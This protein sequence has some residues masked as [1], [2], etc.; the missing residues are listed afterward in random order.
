MS[1]EVRVV[2]SGGVEAVHRG[3]IAIVDADGRTIRAAGDVDATYFARSSLKPFQVQVV[4]RL[5][6]AL[7]G[8]TLALGCAS[9]AGT[10]GHLEVVRRMLEE[11]GLDESS[12]ATPR[13]WPGSL[14]GRDAAVR[15]G[16]R[17][18]QRIFHNCSGKHAGMLRA[19]VASDLP[20]ETYVSPAHPLQVAIR[21][22]VA[23]LLGH[24]PGRPG[25][26]G[27]GAPVYRVSSVGLASMFAGLASDPGRAEVRTTMGAN[28]VLIGG[29]GHE[30]GVIGAAVGAAKFGA[31]ACLGIAVESE[32][33]GIA[34]KVWDGSVRGVAPLAAAALDEVGLL[35]DDLRAALERPVLGGGRTVGWLDADVTWR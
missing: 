27:C 14:D 29:E 16:A 9:H 20:T 17:E 19:C 34:L 21:D 32:G 7:E 4:Q 13:S 15:S 24:D 35:T 1:A 6:A 33:I 22:E 12:L 25:V 18:P 3:A 23:D 30:D 10:P 2:R 5:G 31:E 28:P 11:V 26:D 8:E